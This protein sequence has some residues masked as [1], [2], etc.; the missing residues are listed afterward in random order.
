[1]Y[2]IY[3]PI[4][5]LTKLYEYLSPNIQRFYLAQSAINEC[6]IPYYNLR[7]WQERYVM[8]ALGTEVE[9]FPGKGSGNHPPLSPLKEFDLRSDADNSE[10]D[11]EGQGYRRSGLAA[12]ASPTRERNSPRSGNA[13]D[14]NGNNGGVDSCDMSLD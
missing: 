4:S 13:S 14:H 11:I 6:L 2:S 8:T 10:E 1:M 12:G 3:P 7:E 9:D 5:D